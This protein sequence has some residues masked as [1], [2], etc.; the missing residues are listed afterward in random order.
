MI[1][2]GEQLLRA[3]LGIPVLE[4]C[5]MFQTFSRTKHQ[6]DQKS[7]GLLG[8]I[9]GKN[10]QAGYMAPAKT[11]GIEREDRLAELLSYMRYA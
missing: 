7:K 6:P 3:G 8:P 2:E 1:S 9:D 11:F 4:G 5:P 10:Y